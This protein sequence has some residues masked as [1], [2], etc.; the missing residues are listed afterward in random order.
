M[1]P[2]ASP[3]SFPR[4]DQAKL[5]KCTVL[6]IAS[7][8]SGCTVL[9]SLAMNT[10]TCELCCCGSGC[11]SSLAVN[12]CVSASMYCVSANSCRCAAA[13]ASTC[14]DATSSAGSV[15]AGPSEA[16]S[17]RPLAAGVAAFLVASPLRLSEAAFGNRDAAAPLP[18]LW[19]FA[20]SGGLGESGELRRPNIPP[21][22]PL[23][24]AAGTL[25]PLQLNQRDGMLNV[26]LQCVGA[27]YLQETM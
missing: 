21:G 22:I 24:P 6:L 19:R 14:V 1:N 11:V 17:V 8:Q 5:Q 10:L 13:A 4:T 23:A 2:T 3:I 26:V 16:A 20:G 15:A 9:P 7:W 25:P 27:V 18:L 12:S